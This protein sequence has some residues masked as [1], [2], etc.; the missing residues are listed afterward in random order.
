MD[1]I[2]QRKTDLSAGYTLAIKERER[3]RERDYYR[4]SYPE[5]NILKHSQVNNN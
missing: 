5:T 4:Y 3:E 1:I 2:S